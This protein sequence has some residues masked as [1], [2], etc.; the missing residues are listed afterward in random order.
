[1]VSDYHAVL[2]ANRGPVVAGRNPED[3]VYATEELEETAKL[4][5]AH[6]GMKTRSL[7]PEQ[8]AE[9]RRRFPI[10]TRGQRLDFITIKLAIKPVR[11]SLYWLPMN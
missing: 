10:E 3:A 5:L 9:I 8:G 1:M 11:T 7:K 2:L 6:R 4:F